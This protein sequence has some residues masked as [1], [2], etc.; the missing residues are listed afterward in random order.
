M[1]YKSSC[2]TIRIKIQYGHRMSED[3]IS[4][5]KSFKNR[6]QYEV[7]RA[8]DKPEANQYAEEAAEASAE[9]SA[10]AKRKE[11]QK[12]S[13]QFENQQQTDTTVET[14][15]SDGFSIKRLFGKIG[16]QLQNIV[17][18]LFFPLIALVLSMLVANEMIVYN[19]PIRILFF[20]FTFLLCIFLR[21]YMMALSFFYIVK[22]GYSYY[23]NNMTDGPKR[24]IMPTI[25]ALLPITTYQPVS[26]YGS[27]FIYPFRYPKS[28]EARNKLPELMKDYENQLEESFPGLSQV[29]N[30]PM[31]VKDLENVKEYITH[32]HDVKESPTDLNITKN[33]E[34]STNASSTLSLPTDVNVTKNKAASTSTPL[35]VSLPS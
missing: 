35:T 34:A 29:Q 7:R 28:E 3:N 9:T 31:F 2:G 23:I 5:W 27:F 11:E 22:A 25:F 8:I 30:L 21:S 15:T 26:S 13:E 6:F 33:K 17:S 32:L 19:P 1:H 18:I 14:D 10:E 16:N 24:N 20:L 12:K 4:L